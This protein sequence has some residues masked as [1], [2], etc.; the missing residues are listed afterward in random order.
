MDT[1]DSVSCRMDRPVNTTLRSGLSD[2]ITILTH[3]LMRQKQSKSP[4]QKTVLFITA[5]GALIIGYYWGN[6][7]SVASLEYLNFHPLTIPKKIDHFILSGQSESIFSA[8]NFLQHWNLIIVGHTHLKSASP[9]LTLA[10]QIYNRLADKPNLQDQ[11]Q[12]IYL[13]LD[14]ESAQKKEIEEYV[15]HFNPEFIALTGNKKNVEQ[16][17]EEIGVIF[18][19]AGTVPEQRID[20]SSSLT[21]IAPDGSLVGLFTGRVDAVSISQDLKTLAIKYKSP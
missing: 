15:A 16:F 21:L 4:F 1:V 11:L 5:V 12:I 19:T 17:T 8:E 10:T 9:Q 3:T 18:K 2:L 6:H 13:E 20:H 14:T 7:H